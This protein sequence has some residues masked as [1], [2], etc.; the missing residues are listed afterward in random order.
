VVNNGEERPTR[1]SGAGSLERFTPEAFRA[2]IDDFR[3]RC[4][5]GSPQD[6]EEK[7]EIKRI[8]EPVKNMI[9]TSLAFDLRQAGHGLCCL[10]LVLGVFSVGFI[11]GWKARETLVETNELDKM[12]KG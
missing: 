1:R 2:L 6:L 11:Y 7:K 3:E 8:L 12:L 10:D 5:L 9:A 4:P